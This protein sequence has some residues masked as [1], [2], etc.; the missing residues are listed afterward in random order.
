MFKKNLIYISVIFLGI[1]DQLSSLLM[2]AIPLKAIR[3]VDVGKVRPEIANNFSKINININSN[4]DQFVVLTALIIL[5]LICV[6]ILNIIKNELIKK[7]KIRNIEKLIHSENKKNISEEY[8]N[9]KLQTID[10]FI[11]F[12]T[13]LLYSLILLIGLF[14]YDYLL[15]IIIIFN[16]GLNYFFT[17]KLNSF[18]II[19]GDKNYSNTDDYIIKKIKKD[20][21][22]KNFIKPFIGTFTMICIMTS[23]FLREDI[24]ISFILLFLIRIYLNKINDLISK[25]T[26]NPNFK[27]SIINQIKFKRINK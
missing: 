15:T 3:L 5:M 17:K 12:R 8:I 10:D 23:V 1:V 13:T 18:P 24:T 20:K 7:I 14:Y 16:C 9:K 11:N 22:L 4:T 2:F 26:Q 25:I 19:S 27:K 21:K 6:F